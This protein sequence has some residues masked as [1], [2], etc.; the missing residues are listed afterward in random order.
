MKFDI[1]ISY[2][3]QGGSSYA[4]LIKNDLEKQGFRVYLDM[5]EQNGRDY[6]EEVLA[7]IG[8]TPNFLLLLTKGCIDRCWEEGDMVLEEICSALQHG[9]K[10]IPVA[11]EDF[12]YPKHWPKEIEK[13]RFIDNVIYY[14]RVPRTTIEIIVSRLNL[15]REGAENDTAITLS[16]GGAKPASGEERPQTEPEEQIEIVPS[17]EAVQNFEVG[18]LYYLGVGV[19]KD[20]KT[21]FSWYH[22]AALGGNESA[23]HRIITMY[24]SGEGVE[25][26]VPMSYKW[27]LKAVELGLACGYNALGCCYRDGDCV[28]RNLH[29]ALEY[30]DKAV[31]LG[32]PI[33]HSNAAYIYLT[34]QDG[35][36][37]DYG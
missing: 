19:R 12:E 31:A 29:T 18:E 22:K 5:D 1:F 13:I 9:K 30:F 25:K 15:S 36:E 16:A 20:L 7:R 32:Y 37:T 21:A 17:D 11:T 33:A 27:T 3:R 26:N 24:Y 2:R 8:E 6:R 34:G 10:I 35:V 28:E 23:I 14:E 4:R